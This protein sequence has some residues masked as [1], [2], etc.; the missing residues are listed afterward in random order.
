MYS[1]LAALHMSS[2]NGHA[3]IVNFLIE[4]GAVSL[5]FYFDRQ[6]LAWKER[7]NTCPLYQLIWEHD[8]IELDLWVISLDNP[9]LFFI[10][11]VGSGSGRQDDC[12]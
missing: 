6:G 10:Y 12:M 11:H 8:H 3:T 7:K 4:R 1:I 5:C 2:A 9:P